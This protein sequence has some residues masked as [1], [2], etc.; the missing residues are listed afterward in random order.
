VL[1]PLA[2]AC[3]VPEDVSRR[4]WTDTKYALA[5]QRNLAAAARY[6]VRATP[7]VFFSERHRIDG[8]VP[9]VQFLQTARAAYD[10]Q[11]HA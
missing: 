1:S 8:A 4:A 11:Q 5:L 10:E 6:H 9:F 2:A 7:T 3:G